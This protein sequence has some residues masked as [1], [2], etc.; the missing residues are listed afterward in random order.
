MIIF[1]GSMLL[2]VTRNILNDVNLSLKNGIASMHFWMC[3]IIPK[4]L[5]ND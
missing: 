4:L 3:H 1:V 2:L 5:R